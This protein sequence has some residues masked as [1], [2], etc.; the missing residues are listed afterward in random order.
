MLSKAILMPVRA[1]SAFGE[2]L[3]MLTTATCKAVQMPQSSKRL[4]VSGVGRLLGAAEVS[5]GALLGLAGV[6]A[7]SIR[8]AGRPPFALIGFA[9]HGVCSLVWRVCM[10]MLRF[11]PGGYGTPKVVV[12]LVRHPFGGL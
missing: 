5:M 12:P 4:G 9:G 11:T 6:G 3:A 1:T 2:A 8:K 10:L 7:A